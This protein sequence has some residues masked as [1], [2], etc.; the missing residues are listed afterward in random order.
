LNQN[1]KI[2]GGLT[3]FM[4]MVEALVIIY[5]FGWGIMLILPGTTL[6]LG[7]ITIYLARK[8]PDM[9][10]TGKLL[11]EFKRPPDKEIQ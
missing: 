2:I 5:V 9:S 7:V 6:T 11:E 4:A 1:Q 8:V 3:F 10:G